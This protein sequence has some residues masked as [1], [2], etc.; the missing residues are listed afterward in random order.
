MNYGKI[1]RV[2]VIVCALLNATGSYA[3][4]GPGETPIDKPSKDPG[5]KPTR[6]PFDTPKYDPGPKFTPEPPKD[7][8]P[9]PSRDPS[10]TPIRIPLGPKPR[11]GYSNPDR[12]PGS[13][14]LEDWMGT[15][16]GARSAY[17][18]YRLNGRP[19]TYCKDFGSMQACQKWVTETQGVNGVCDWGTCR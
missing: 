14:G 19:H 12:M 17:A 15:L 10:D 9:S 2:G 7:P 13:G 18:L 4:E 3:Q 6:D 16:I 1:L 8:R 5:D 11:A